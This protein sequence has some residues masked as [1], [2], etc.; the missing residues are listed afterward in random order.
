MSLSKDIRTR[1][2][3]VQ[4]KIDQAAARSGRA[5]SAV[6]LVVVTKAQPVDV[7]QAVIDADAK[8]LGENYPEE[9]IQ[10]LPKLVVPKDVEWHMIGHLQSRKSR[11]VADSFTLF[12]A[13]D[14]LGL[15]QKLDRIL[16]DK[17]RILDVLLECN[18]GEEESKH[19]WNV[20]TQQLVDEFVRDVEMISQ[21]KQ[22]RIKGLMCMPP[23]FEDAQ[24]TR[25]YFIRLRN[26]RDQLRMQFPLIEWDDLSMGTSLDYEVAVEE[27]ATFVRVGTAIVGPRHYNQV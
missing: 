22:L 14:S 13:L 15:A 5:S 3:I 25:P 23:L 20:Q 18:V 16:A 8:I 24:Q 21:L 17:G 7:M 11:I 12:Q 4:E 9:T 1:I 10:K 19:G 2:E 26:L 27:G 6:K